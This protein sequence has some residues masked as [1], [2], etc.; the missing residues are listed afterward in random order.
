MYPKNYSWLLGVLTLISQPVHAAQVNN[1]QAIYKQQKTQA[2]TLDDAIATALAQSPN[3]KAYDSAVRAAQGVTA[4]AGLWSNPEL[5][6]EAEN[7]AGR[8]PY[9][10]INSAEM[11]YGISQELQVGGKLSAQKKIAGKGQ[12]IA[13]LEQQAA[14]L[15]MIREVTI[16]YTEAVAADE[17]VRLAAEQAELA[18]DVLKSVKRRVDAAASPLI[19]KS[20]AEVEQASAMMTQDKAQRD[21]RIAMQKLAAL[22]GDGAFSTTIDNRAFYQL[23]KPGRMVLEQN[24]KANPD[25]IK[26]NSYLEQSQANLALERA[27]ATPNPRINLGVRDFRENDSQA[28]V[29]GVSFPIP[30]FNANRGNIEKARYDISRIEQE[31]QQ[32]TL[33]TNTTF[34][35]AYE[36]ME[37]AYLQ[38]E[39]LKE[40]ILPAANKAFRLAREG[41]GLGRFPYLEV[42][43]AQRSLFSVRQQQIEALK[44]FHIAKAQA[45][46]LGAAH[47]AMIQNTGAQHVK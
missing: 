7:I 26:L 24:R 32:A 27:N 31:N 29:A 16:A 41:Y 22:M 28:F 14:M 33:D 40:T 4:Q 9:K 23:E 39:T 18:G 46:R 34:I 38:A 20:R 10:G 3:L 8:T 45:E 47:L 11:T 30:V 35:A 21:Y 2:L 43:D 17:I 19:Q 37:N 42:L 36:Q 44:N 15:D 12:E 6:I 1:K 25:L 5:G 13:S